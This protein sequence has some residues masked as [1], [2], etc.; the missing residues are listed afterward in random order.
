LPQASTSPES[1][2]PAGVSGS[3]TP[4]APTRRRVH[5]STDAAWHSVETSNTDSRK[6]VPR[7]NQRRR[8]NPASRATANRTSRPDRAKM[9]RRERDRNALA[10]ALAE[11]RSRLP[12]LRE[13][14]QE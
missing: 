13:L 11:R 14:R 12:S 4:V 6:A 2:L 5:P 1:S 7:R 9:Q 10:T 8:S 3:E